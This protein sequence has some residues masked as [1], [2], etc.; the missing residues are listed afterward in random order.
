MIRRFLRIYHRL[1]NFFTRVPHDFDM[2]NISYRVRPI[3]E[4]IFD[5]AEIYVCRECGFIVLGSRWAV[6][7]LQP[8]LKYGCRGRLPEKKDTLANIIVTTKG[9]QDAS[10]SIDGKTDTKN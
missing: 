10:A 2:Y 7:H 4:G 8:E 6:Q 9:I 1:C 3:G 5:V